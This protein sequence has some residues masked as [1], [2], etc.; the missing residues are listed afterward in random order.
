MQLNCNFWS[1]N[2]IYDLMITVAVGL[3]PSKRKKAV[4]IL[5][6]SIF[7]PNNL[8]LVI[9]GVIKGSS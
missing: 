6:R 2:V 4:M 3:Q 8:Q 1:R 5:F 7:A 9:C